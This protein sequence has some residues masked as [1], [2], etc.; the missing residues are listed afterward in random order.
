M[1]KMQSVE[2]PELSQQDRLRSRRLVQIASAVSLSLLAAM[3][4]YIS[5]DIWNVVAAL[6]MGLCL[7]GFCLYLNAA[8]RTYAGNMLLLASLWVTLSALAWIAEG[9][10]DVT[11]LTYPVLLVLAGLLVRR[12]YFFFMLASM[13]AFLVFMTLSTEVFHWR[14]DSH[15]SNNWDVLRDSLIILLVSGYAVWII[16]N[17]LHVSMQELRDQIKSFK[18]SQTQLTYLSQHD[19]LTGLPNRSLGRDRI[20]RAI[21]HA[22]RN[23]LR[24]A[25]LF[26]D[27]DNFKLINDSLGHSVG[28]DYLKQIAFRLQTAVRKT[29]IVSRHGGD[30]FVI[31]LTDISDVQDVSNAATAVLDRM[32]PSF[33]AK[34]VELTGSCSI[35]IAMFPEDGNDYES[36]LREADIAMYQAKEAGRN[37]FRFFDADMNAHIQQN[38]QLV[39]NLRSA[40]AHQEFVLYYQPVMDLATGKL[41]GAEALLRW[42]HPEKGMIPPVQ[43]IPAA[44][45]SGL[46]VELGEWVLEESCRQLVEWQQS[47]WHDFVMA[48]NLSTVQFRRGNIEVMVESVLQKTGLNPAC[49]ELEITESTLIDDTEKFIMSLQ[50]L[51]RLGI[52]ISIDDFGTG[53]SNLSYLQR[54]SVDKLK[55]DQSF[56]MRLK[57]GTQERAIVSAI[58]QMAKSLNL[59]TTA[60][61][62]EDAEVGE[63][64]LRLGCTLGQGY[65][66]ARP[67]PAQEFA[68]RQMRVT[69]SGIPS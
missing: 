37:T 31:G 28:D 68:L 60:E 12:R 13:A 63:E 2:S 39:S 23:R 62:I 20:E 48:V 25:L 7:M 30:E 66:Y 67:L 57:Q 59:K 19:T 6:G 61:G 43:F 32:K 52:K 21:L 27:L 4:V 35:G 56:V 53:Y 50:K 5:K 26:V 55:I 58:I 46:I 47:G 11:I 16:I 51:K 45:K 29:D 33:S 24:V 44:E 69:S 8:G 3:A 9:L 17:D 36:L 14:A 38:L 54:F 10:H 22:S 40:L 34:D 18:A 64:L 41:V 15:A 1:P 49:L 65:F 42:I